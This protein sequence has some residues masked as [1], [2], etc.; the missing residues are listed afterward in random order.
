MAWAWAGSCGC[1]GVERCQRWGKQNKLSCLRLAPT[2]GEAV[3]TQSVFA[4]GMCTHTISM[5]TQDAPNFDA[6]LPFLRV[7]CVP[8]SY[9][10][11]EVPCLWKR[12]EAR[13]P[14]PFAEDQEPR[15]LVGQPQERWRMERPV[16]TT[17]QKINTG[18]RKF[19]Q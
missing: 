6:H 15:N 18:S 8:D 5:H 7:A 9:D 4:Q 19:S 16:S 10:D 3:E 14:H 13:D 17:T 1:D 2:S 11:E 12:Q